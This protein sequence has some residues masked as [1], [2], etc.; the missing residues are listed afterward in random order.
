MGKD[1]RRP[2]ESESKD[3]GNQT[4]STC[5]DNARR[6]ARPRATKCPTEATRQHTKVAWEGYHEGA[7]DG[8]GEEGWVREVA[9]GTTAAIRWL[10]GG[11]RCRWSKGKDLMLKGRDP[12]LV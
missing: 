10:E 12:M 3:R 8:E 1:G 9:R 11:I 4:Y 7:R 5:V 6:E 2:R